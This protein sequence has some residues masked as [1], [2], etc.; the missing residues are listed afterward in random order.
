MSSEGKTFN[1][2]PWLIGRWKN[3][4]PGDSKHAIVNLKTKR[5]SPLRNTID[6][7]YGGSVY[8]P[9]RR[10]SNMHNFIEVNGTPFPYKMRQQLQQSWL[11]QGC[12]NFRMLYHSKRDVNGD[13]IFTRYY[14]VAL[15]FILGINFFYWFWCSQV[16]A[17]SLLVFVNQNSTIKGDTAI[18]YL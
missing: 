1:G 18:D 4:W 11:V 3:T 2:Q 7:V 10:W 6:D 17:R 16:L 12:R 15:S 14:R 5:R 13:A 9:P 8:I